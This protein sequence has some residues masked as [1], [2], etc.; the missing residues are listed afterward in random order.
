VIADYIEF[1]HRLKDWR[2]QLFSFRSKKSMPP[3]RASRTSQ[4]AAAAPEPQQPEQQQ[5]QQQIPAPTPDAA[6]TALLQMLQV[7]QQQQLQQQELISQ[8]RQQQSAPQA[9]APAAPLTL[10]L[11]TAQDIPKLKVLTRE[12]FLVWSRD[13]DAYLGRC[14]ADGLGLGLV[15]GQWRK[16]PA[17]MF[18]TPYEK[19]KS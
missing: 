15:V 11:H 8:L 18:S 10:A 17:L 3:K 5:Q 2:F 12:A 13:I 4:A 19:H 6:T 1:N 16:P 7:M 14:Q 9:L